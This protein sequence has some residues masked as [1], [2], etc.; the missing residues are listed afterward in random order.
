MR[1]APAVNTLSNAASTPSIISPPNTRHATTVIPE[2]RHAHI[3]PP[4]EVSLRE[5]I[6][7]S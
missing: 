4:N 3:D 1:T 5:G 7:D 2:S 6:C